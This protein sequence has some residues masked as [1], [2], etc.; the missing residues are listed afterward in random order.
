MAIKR[1]GVVSYQADEALKT[2]LRDSGSKN[3]A[4][5]LAAQ[6]ALAQAVTL[7]MRQGILDGDIVGEFGIFVP[8][9][10]DTNIQVEYPLDIIVPGTEGDYNA[11]TIPNVG[12]IPEKNVE[13]D[14]VTIPTYDVGNAIDFPIKF[15]QDARW[16][17]VARCLQVLE[18]GF[19]RKNNADAWKLM[20]AAGLDRNVF[21]Y[22]SQAPIGFTTK[23]LFSLMKTQIGR[24]GGGNFQAANRFKL[25]DVF[26][27]PEALE[28][29]RNWDLT[30]IDDVT[31]R[32]IF[33]AGR[34]GGLANVFGVDLHE[35]Y[36]L[37][38]NQVL[39]TYFTSLGGSFQNG[40]LELMIGLSLGND[41]AGTC[42][43]NP[44]KEQLQVFSD[45]ALHRQRR[46]GYYAWE[47]HGYGLL[48]NR[49]I[50]L[51]TA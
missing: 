44:V 43:V 45:E 8:T 39:Q 13:G 35:L 20:T 34:D 6:D 32:E 10:F 19:V 48:D 40:D 14:Y 25:T 37:G 15:A 11:F 29:L 23:R 33:M 49:R 31:R 36:E 16:D 2:L 42:F 17:I 47:S 38:E 46:Q 7:P 24:S 12:R 22:D 3:K 4:V 50:L 28:D 26:M 18:N 41:D 51:A 30:Q 9:V 1:K 27:S 5:A 21:V